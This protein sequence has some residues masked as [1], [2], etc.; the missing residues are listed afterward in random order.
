MTLKSDGKFKEKVLCGFKYYIK[1]LVNFDPT[2]KSFKN[3]H[4]NGLFLIKIYNVWVL[5]NTEELAVIILR[6]NANFEGKMTC[7]FMKYMRS[8]VNLT[9]APKIVIFALWETFLSKIF[10]V[11]AK[12]IQ[13]N[14]VSWH[15]KMMQY[16]KK[17]GRWF[18]KLT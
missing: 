8:L 10:N 1:N 3:L 9:G 17:I 13:R 6:I 16:L 11:W 5:K 15:W 2:L 14:Y 4:F 18:E 12:K 7:F